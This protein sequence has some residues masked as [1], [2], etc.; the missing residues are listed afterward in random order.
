MT[1]KILLVNP[2]IYDFAA[3]DFGIKPLGLLRIGEYLRRQ[4]NEI[5]LLD[6][7]DGCSRSR[8]GFGFSKIRKEKIESPPIFAKIKR[9][10]FRYGISL[11]DFNKK[12]EG[13]PD[14][15]E[16]FIT[17]GMTYWYPGVHLAI[18]LLRGR[19]GKVPITLGG[20]YATLCHKHACLTSSA[21]T[22]WKGDYLGEEY[23]FEA[24]FYPAYDLL[25][26]KDVL[27]I[28][29]TRGCPFRC[30][31]CASKILNPGFGIKD[32]VNLFEEVMHYN[33]SF[34][35]VSF[36]FYDDALTYHS[37][38]GI[39]RFLRMVIASGN[40]FT[41]RTP[42]GLHA[43]FIDEELAELLKKS[44]FRDLRLSLE[45]SDENIQV[46]TGGKVTNND[47]KL[48]I[49]NLKE[50]GFNKQDI[51]VY[52]LIGAPWLDMKKTIDDIMFVNSLDVKAILASYSPIPG[53]KDYKALV[54][55]KTLTN[56]TDPLWHNKTVFPEFLLPSYSENIQR[57]RRFTSG[58]NKSGGLSNG[59]I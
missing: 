20:I 2:W 53:T 30:T 41:F 10:Y 9:P 33:K 58:L 19:F 7:L 45:T 31:Y 42:N 35:T 29:L 26:E 3:Y 47:T 48:A 46:F 43:K 16:I 50:A 40:N 51:G 38:Y 49:R 36:V 6:C 22:V 4:G 14:I 57:I 27:P 25:S 24:N 23:Y 28:Q 59:R 15:D 13:M 39:K 55:N 11:S 18:K 54:K 5:Y 37:D 1:K 56:N 12:L 8:D 21:D 32:P 52:L 34:G 17:S 44:G